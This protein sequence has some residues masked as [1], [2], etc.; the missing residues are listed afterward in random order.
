MWPTHGCRLVEIAAMPGAICTYIGQYRTGLKCPKTL[1]AH[2]GV[3]YPHVQGRGRGSW[4]DARVQPSQNPRVAGWHFSWRFCQKYTPEL[5]EHLARAVE[6]TARPQHWNV[7]DVRYPQQAT[8]FLQPLNE[9]AGWRPPLRCGVREPCPWPCSADKESENSLNSHCP[10]VKFCYW[11]LLL[12]D[13]IF[14]CTHSP[15]SCK[16]VVKYLPPV[17]EHDAVYK[18]SWINEML[19]SCRHFEMRVSSVV[20]WLL[21]FGG[22]QSHKCNDLTQSTWFGNPWEKSSA[23]QKGSELGKFGRFYFQYLVKTFGRSFLAQILD[24]VP[25]GDATKI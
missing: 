17:T 1:E 10:V 18:V 6:R 15:C 13:K 20:S 24:E 3:H 22:Y 8:V 9:G 16:I 19:C 21:Q 5:C 4:V 12:D 25:G 7:A 23:M 11:L 2:Q 14:D